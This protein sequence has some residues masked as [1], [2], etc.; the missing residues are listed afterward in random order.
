MPERRRV[1]VVDDDADVRQALADQLRLHG[2]AVS[3]AAD[4]LSA[5]TEIRQNPPL[6]VLLDLAMPRLGGLETLKMIRDFDPALV[7][8][9]VTGYADPEMHQRAVNL[10]AAAVLQKPVE[11]PQ[12]EKALGGPADR[13]P[14]AARVLVVDDDA[15]VR[16]FLAELL[17]AHGYEVATAPNGDLALQELARQSTDVVLLDVVLPGLSGDELMQAFA[18]VAPRVKIIIVSGGATPVQRMRTFARGAFDYFFK[19]VNEARL[20]RSIDLAVSMKQLE[21]R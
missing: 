18:R 6:A 2:F 11:W 15:D 4:G 16:E 12:L 20:L 5:W 3:E 1:L 21:S 17:T 13:S 14:A 19:P 10:G 7:T 9:V 8:I